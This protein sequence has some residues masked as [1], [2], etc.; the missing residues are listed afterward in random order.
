[1][2]ALESSNADSDDAE[3]DSPTHRDSSAPTR[4]RGRSFD[5]VAD[6]AVD[7]VA[8]GALSRLT[9]ERNTPVY[10]N[11]YDLVRIIFLPMQIYFFS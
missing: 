6:D 8:Y 10:L 11:V 2:S 7:E 5:D 9:G 3:T 4:P 1:M